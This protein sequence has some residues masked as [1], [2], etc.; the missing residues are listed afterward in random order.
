MKDEIYNTGF[1]KGN[2]PP[3]IGFSEMDDWGS[4]KWKFEGTPGNTSDKFQTY[5]SGWFDGRNQWIKENRK[6]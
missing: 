1:Q 3:C 2:S 4:D 6:N 5:Q